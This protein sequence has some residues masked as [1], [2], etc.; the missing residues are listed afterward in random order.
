MNK[1]TGNDW[2]SRLR[3]QGISAERI[4]DAKATSQRMA[5]ALASVAFTPAD[6]LAPDEFQA[7]LAGKTGGRDAS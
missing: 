5:D 2:E 7:I 6:S 1:T 3:A 4:A